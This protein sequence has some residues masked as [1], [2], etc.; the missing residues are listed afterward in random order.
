MTNGLLGLTLAILQWRLQHY[1]VSVWEVPR[2]GEVLLATGGQWVPNVRAV[3]ERAG[4]TLRPVVGEQG[5]AVEGQFRVAR[6]GEPSVLTVSVFCSGFT[7]GDDREVTEHELPAGTV[8][9]DVELY[10][11]AGPGGGDV[12]L[13]E[14][15][16]GG[17][18]L[19]QMAYEEVVTS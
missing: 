16:I 14:A 3:V 9:R 6:P 7:S 4:L 12:Y 2:T 10:Q 18:W 1:P 15:R 11:G 8:V 5:R 17:V 19:T 13:F